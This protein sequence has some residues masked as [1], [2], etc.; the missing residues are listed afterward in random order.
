[1][2][3][4]HEG[5]IVINNLRFVI[6]KN[7]TKE[8]FLFSPLSKLIFNSFE[9]ANWISY[10]I[11]PQ[12]ILRKKFSLTFTFKDS[13]FESLA[14]RYSE[15]EEIPYDEENEEKRKAVHDRW[16]QELFGEPHEYGPYW[17]KYKFTWGSILSSLD[18][19]AGQSEIYLAFK[20]SDSQ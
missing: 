20:K 3:D 8:K 17:N 10:S 11:E 14:L 9:S 6:D 15:M 13:I 7:L 12:H 2:L 16:L 4:L 18:P 5:K 19:R 1:M